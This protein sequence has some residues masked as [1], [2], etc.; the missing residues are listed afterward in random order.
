MES[1]LHAVYSTT[2]DQR[3]YCHKNWATKAI[4]D[5]ITVVLHRSWTHNPVIKGNDLL[6]ICEE[7]LAWTCCLETNMGI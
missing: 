6:L 5:G 1:H 7:H 3:T 2:V 4:A